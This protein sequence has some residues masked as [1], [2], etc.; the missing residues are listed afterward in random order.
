MSW[1]L[2]RP[3]YAPIAPTK[4]VRV[5]ALLTMAAATAL[6]LAPVE[7]AQADAGL[8]EYVFK[9]ASTSR[10]LVVAQ[11]QTKLA[12][13]APSAKTKLVNQINSLLPIPALPEVHAQKK[14][15]QKPKPEGSLVSRA[16]KNTIK[17]LKNFAPGAFTS[18]RVHSGGRQEEVWLDGNRDLQFEAWQKAID[19]MREAVAEKLKA[20]LESGAFAQMPEADRAR[21]FE[22]FFEEGAIMKMKSPLLDYMVRDTNRNDLKQKL[23]PPKGSIGFEQSRTEFV[24]M[25]EWFGENLANGF[26]YL[27][28]ANGFGLI[29]ER[30]DSTWR[31]WPNNYA[32]SQIFE[33]FVSNEKNRVG[34]LSLTPA[35]LQS[36][37]DFNYWVHTDQMRIEFFKAVATIYI[38]PMLWA[39]ASRFP[40]E[41]RYNHGDAFK[42]DDVTEVYARLLPETIA[43]MNVVTDVSSIKQQQILSELRAK[44]PKLFELR[45]ELFDRVFPQLETVLSPLE[46]IHSKWFDSSRNYLYRIGLAIQKADT[47][48]KKSAFVARAKL[49]RPHFTVVHDALNA[50][51]ANSKRI[52]SELEAYVTYLRVRRALVDASDTQAI[53]NWNWVLENTLAHQVINQQLLA[54][55]ML[56]E[57]ELTQIDRAIDRLS[58]MSRAGALAIAS[59]GAGSR[60]GSSAGLLAPVDGVG[61]SASPGLPAK[62]ENE[63]Y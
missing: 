25:A 7:N 40:G 56:K 17:F 9:G 6:V 24:N 8:C 22:F 19:P 13:T 15:A 37:R 47:S 32:D 62:G 1:K 31:S 18:E 20:T 26:T 52:A 63:L 41:G 54:S 11:P 10:E 28:S 59:G 27:M 30:S 3:S 39:R 14:N 58:V 34:F 4:C 21:I 53:D 36:Y 2:K 29:R 51:R 5:S 61:E 35:E 60:T 49:L 43:R 55:I 44:N 12:L 33:N 48:E 42:A 38:E 50:A 16:Y 57:Q 46:S 23:V 45:A